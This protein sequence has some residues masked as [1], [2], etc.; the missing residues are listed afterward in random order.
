M[1][2]KVLPLDFWMKHPKLLEDCLSTDRHLPCIPHFNRDGIYSNYGECW[3][4]VNG[5]AYTYP[6]EDFNYQLN[7]LNAEELTVKQG[8]ALEEIIKQK[9]ATK[10]QRKLFQ[11]Y[12]E[13]MRSKKCSRHSRKLA[14]PRMKYWKEKIK[15]K[16]ELEN[17]K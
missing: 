15:A 3:F 9:L 7:M 4:E 5:K 10:E 11:F 6:V 12:C 8:E 13:A 1:T 2:I 14:I 16:R 17:K